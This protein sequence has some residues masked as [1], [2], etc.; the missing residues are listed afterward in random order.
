MEDRS[1]P[2][3]LTKSELKARVSAGVIRTNNL[4]TDDT[5]KY[6]FQ[7]REASRKDNS[8]RKRAESKLKLQLTELFVD[9]L[10]L[11]MLI[12]TKD[13]LSYAKIERCARNLRKTYPPAV[14][15]EIDKAGI[16]EDFYSQVCLDCFEHDSCHTKPWDLKEK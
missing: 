15:E 3:K 12:D 1:K 10:R 5:L 16:I 6:M 11:A 9:P 4:L 7:L 8:E 2:R 14:F 13:T